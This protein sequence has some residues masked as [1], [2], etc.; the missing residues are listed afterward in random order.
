[1]PGAP[2]ILIIVLTLFVSVMAFLAIYSFISDSKTTG[3]PPREPDFEDVSAFDA[4][5]IS[6]IDAWLQ[7]QVDLAKYPSLA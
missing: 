3:E 6:R 7:Q 1:L 5:D 4:S 2:A